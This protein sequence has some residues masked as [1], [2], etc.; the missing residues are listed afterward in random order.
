MAC[1]ACPTLSEMFGQKYNFEIC[2]NC[3]TK[4]K[5]LMREPPSKILQLP[6]LFS[7]PKDGK[8]MVHTTFAYKKQ[9][10]VKC[11][12]CNKKYFGNTERFVCLDCNLNCCKNCREKLWKGKPPKC[13]QVTIFLFRNVE[14]VM[15]SSLSSSNQKH[16]NT[17]MD[18]CPS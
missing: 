11:H 14:W 17:V 5:M 6:S 1:F 18:V 12:Y 13:A 3:A 9:L 10:V 7:C 2:F 8:P 4:S 15:N 16:C